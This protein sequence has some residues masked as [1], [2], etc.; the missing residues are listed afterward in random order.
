[1]EWFRRDIDPKSNTR[2]IA[3]DLEGHVWVAHSGGEVSRF[4]QEE[5]ITL[6]DAAMPTTFTI[7]GL[8]APFNPA[9]N[10]TIGVGI[11]RNGACWVVSRN[12]GAENGAATRILPDDTMESFPVGKNPYTYSDFTGFGLFQVVRPSGYWRGI[13]EGCSVDPVSDW[14]TLTWG[15]SEPPGTSVRVRVRVA[16]TIP[17]LLIAPWYGPWDTSPVD[18][19]AA[20]VPTSKYMQ[21]EVQLSTTDPNITPAFTGFQLVFDCA[22]VNP[23]D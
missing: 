16:D 11:D 2:G 23:V 19:D 18:L 3:V 8:P 10:A 7:P 17:D 12:D 20:G 13:L 1:M 15:E 14:Q 21:V 5:V 6:G 22:S 4:L 9:I